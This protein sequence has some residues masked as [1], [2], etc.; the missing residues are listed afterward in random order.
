[1]NAST[2]SLMESGAL[3]SNRAFQP[4]EALFVFYLYVSQIYYGYRYIFQYGSEST[5]GTYSDTPMPFQ[6]AKYV[7]TAV[8]FVGSFTILLARNRTKIHLSRSSRSFL[9]L[10]GGFVGYSLA[11]NLTMVSEENSGGDPAFL[12]AFFFLPLLAL[13]PF[14]YQGR[15][16][17]KSYV[18]V[19]VGFGLVYHT[20]YTI[21][22]VLCYLLFGRLPALA[23]I[24]ALVRFGGGWDDPNGFGTFLALPLLIFLGSRFV[25]GV[26]RYFGVFL[27]IT[28]LGLTTSVT[29]IAACIVG[30]VWYAWLKRRMFVVFL[31]VVPPVVL[32]AASETLQDLLLY[33]YQTKSQS[34]QEHLDQFSIADFLRDSNTFELLL[35]N[36]LA[37]GT[38]NESFYLSLLQ[39][40]GIIGLL[41]LGAIITLT[42]AN[43]LHKIS[44]AKRNRDLDSAEIFTVLA[45]FIAGFCVASAITP[46][47]YVFPVN[48]YF[49]LAVFL[50]WLAPAS[51]IGSTRPIPSK[52]VYAL[53]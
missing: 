25:S 35:G 39:N 27:V 11:I 13:L 9:V 17:L 29:G 21:A 4:M 22:Q 24:G 41:W 53:N 46:S 15:E 18:G 45:C 23:F 51:C 8:L 14:H 40:Y 19:V 1:M 32:V 20:I 28:L 37:G 16:S 36:H 34:A 48:F 10:L 12:K 33:A 49:W 44:A 31:I 3:K 7:L 2:Q 38:R 30:L 47:F 26:K 42:L 5:S 52:T 6:V 43:A 50:I